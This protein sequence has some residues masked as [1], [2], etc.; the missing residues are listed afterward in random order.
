MLVLGPRR[1]LH[2]ERARVFVMDHQLAPA[3]FAFV[4]GLDVRQPRDRLHRC[5][6]S[7]LRERLG[8]VENPFVRGLS[9]QQGRNDKQRVRQRSRGDHLQSLLAPR[10]RIRD[11]LALHLRGSLWDG[12][13]SQ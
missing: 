12:L 9:R 11:V 2:Q 1:L 4:L 13:V 6:P 8:V 10:K 7:G 5:L 3:G